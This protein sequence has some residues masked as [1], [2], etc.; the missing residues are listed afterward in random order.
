MSQT[1]TITFGS[2][3]QSRKITPRTA[4]HWMAVLNAIPNSKLLLKSKNLGE[5]VER[6]RNNAIS[7]DGIAP[8]RLE[9]RGHSP[10]W[11]STSLPITMWT[12]PW[13]LSLTP[14][15]PPPL[16][17]LWMGV[18]VLTIAGD[19]MVSRQAAAVL[20]GVGCNQWICRNETEM[21]EQALSLTNNQDRLRKAA[22]SS[23]GNSVA[24]SELLDHAGLAIS[25]R[26]P[27]AAGGCD[28]CSSKAG[29]SIRN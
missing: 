12:S 22:A 13:T 10:T 24:Q 2:F 26:R 11:K 19:S 8:E 6:E 17:R 20:N 23:N 29:R 18:P 14:A 27:F 7:R 9:L 21:V 28:G 15:A 25:L 4:S 16:M 1:K 3:N 5:Q